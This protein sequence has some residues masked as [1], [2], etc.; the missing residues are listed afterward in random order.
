LFAA[1]GLN[2]LFPD[3]A[4]ACTAAYPSRRLASRTGGGS[5]DPLAACA[6]ACRRYGV[7]LHVW[8]RC[9]SLG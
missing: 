1:S 8:M 3:M 7:R 5:G 6:A 2:A 9:F 4:D